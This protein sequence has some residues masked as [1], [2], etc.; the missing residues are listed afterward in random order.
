[1]TD[2]PSTLPGPDENFHRQVRQSGK[3][4]SGRPNGAPAEAESGDTSK[5]QDD[6]SE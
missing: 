4:M 6:G 2:G 1:M 3:D 5:G